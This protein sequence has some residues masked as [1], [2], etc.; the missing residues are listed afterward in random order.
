MKRLKFNVRIFVK[1]TKKTDNQDGYLVCRVRWLNYETVMGLGCPINTQKWDDN[2]QRP[3]KGTTHGC[4]AKAMPAYEINR[5]IQQLTDAIDDSFAKFDV[6]RIIPSKEALK[7]EIAHRLT[8]APQMSLKRKEAQKEAQN[9]RESIYDWFDVFLDEGENVHHWSIETTNKFLTL[10]SHLRSFDSKL[11]F[12]VLDADK[13]KSFQIYLTAKQL[14]NIT[15]QKLFQNFRWFLRWCYNRKDPLINDR[16]VVSY[17]CSLKDVE[18]KEIVYLTWDEFKQLYNC[19]IPKEKH[20]LERAKD[21]FVFACTTGLRYSDVAALTR[22]KVKDDEITVVTEKTDDVIRIHLNKYSR[23][24]LQKYQAIPFKGDLAL[25][26]IS[27]QKINGYLKELGKLAGIDAPV[28]IAYRLG[29]RKYEEVK[30][31]YKA[32]SFHAG[33]RTYVSLALKL[34]ATPEEVSRVSGHHSYQIMQ[35]YMAQDDEQRRHATSVFDERSERDELMER[36]AQMSNDEL[37][38]LLNKNL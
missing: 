23:E 11:S 7:T 6:E 14:R 19:E 9:N 38:R 5:L 20:Y 34:G 24:V 13:M 26:V 28:T 30:P 33:R 1:K 21:L 8:F 3:L 25:P 27:N 4:G 37:H 22:K 35:R 10:R 18:H 15:V 16:S 29:S 31:K 2:N 17:K 12:S 36:I 32:L